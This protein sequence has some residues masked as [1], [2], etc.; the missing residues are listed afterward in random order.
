M[1]AVMKVEG[2][3]KEN[4]Q[5]HFDSWDVN[6]TTYNNTATIK[7][8]SYTNTNRFDFIDFE[9]PVVPKVPEVPKMLEINIESLVF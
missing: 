7:S 2:V 5:T 1:E 6:L 8:K 9:I 4:A 3:S